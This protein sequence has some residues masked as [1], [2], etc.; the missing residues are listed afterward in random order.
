MDFFLSPCERV[1]YGV[2]FDYFNK[3]DADEE[4]ALKLIGVEE[5]QLIQLRGLRNGRI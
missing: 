5:R 4:Y 2:Y 1:D 3:L